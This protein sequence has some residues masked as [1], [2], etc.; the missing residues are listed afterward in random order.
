[1]NNVEFKLE[2]NDTF[3]NYFSHCLQEHENVEFCSYQR[4][5]FLEKP[6][7][8]FFKVVHHGE[9]SFQ[10]ILQEVQQIMRSKINEI[11]DTFEW[12]LQNKKLSP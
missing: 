3:A 10:S 8:C 5:H 6:E 2:E 11:E 9:K 12:S 1:M 7:F 4:S